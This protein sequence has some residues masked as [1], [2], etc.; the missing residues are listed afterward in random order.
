MTSGVGAIIDRIRAAELDLRQDILD[1]ERRWRYRLR[2]RRPLFPHDV[3]RGHQSFKIPW[4]TFL[5]AARPLPLLTAPLIYSLGV[6]LVLLDLW[7]TLYQHVCFPIYGI[8]RV[9]RRDHFAID[10]HRLAY[11]NSVEKLHCLY[12]S[13]A[14]GLLAYVREIAARTEQYWCPI[15]HARPTAAPH[16]RYH[17]FVDYGDAEGY[18]REQEDLRRSFFGPHEDLPS[19]PARPPWGDRPPQ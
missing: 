3:R 17:L 13:Y 14:N 10:R 2:H 4:L 15:K 8:P 7:M 19:G 9:N 6:P 1:Q 12:C 11:L 16:G 5:K 18:R